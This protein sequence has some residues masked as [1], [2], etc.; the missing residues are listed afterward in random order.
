MVWLKK[1]DQNHISVS[2]SDCEGSC[3]KKQ[4][5]WVPCLSELTALCLCC[6]LIT[7]G[8][9][10]AQRNLQ[11]AAFHTEVCRDPP[12]LPG[13]SVW[14]WLEVQHTLRMPPAR[15]RTRTR[16]GWCFDY[17]HF[18]T[19]V[20]GFEHL[21]C[22]LLWSNTAVLHQFHPSW[23]FWC[24]CLIWT[25]LKEKSSWKHVVSAALTVCCIIL[26]GISNILSA[27]FIC[28]DIYNYLMLS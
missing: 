19:T 6:V 17:L 27:L 12:K 28:M 14:Q 22:E 9:C 20:A 21:S 15:T 2:R 10:W 13:Q 8:L 26:R 3:L 7:G 5:N 25:C 24:S 1:L 11:P 16:A 18:L 23:W 4:L